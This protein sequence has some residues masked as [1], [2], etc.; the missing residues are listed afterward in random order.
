MML[1]YFAVLVC[2]KAKETHLNWYLFIVQFLIKI[3]TAAVLI[4]HT[5]TKFANSNQTKMC[6]GNH[7][8]LFNRKWIS[9]C[10]INRT[11]PNARNAHKKE[12]NISC[13]S[14]SWS[15]SD[16]EVRQRLLR[17]ALICT[18]FALVRQ[19]IH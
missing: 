18:T 17:S 9:R 19:I 4:T 7:V 1:A 2:I 6:H 10:A 8:E 11:Q 15:G 13:A 16:N 14:S 3:T 12:N 5:H